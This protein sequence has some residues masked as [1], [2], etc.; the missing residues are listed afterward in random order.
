MHYAVPIRDKHRVR[1]RGRSDW[2][3]VFIATYHIAPSELSS[4]KPG[5]LN[6]VY[7]VV[8]I[9]EEE[10]DLYLNV[11]TNVSGSKD[12]ALYFANYFI[13]TQ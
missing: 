7:V 5:K 6:Q 12:W 10:N 1:H 13:L 11:K 3:R 4:Y 8:T 9:F 2:R